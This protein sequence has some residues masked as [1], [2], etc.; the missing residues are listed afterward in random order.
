[1]AAR[2]GAAKAASC[3]KAHQ[4]RLVVVMVM[5]VAVFMRMVVLMGMLVAMFMGMFVRVGMAMGLTVMRVLMR[6]LMG[7]LVRVFMILEELLI[8]ACLLGAAA[9]TFTHIG[10]LDA[11]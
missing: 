1:M 10:L 2:Q 3:A 5:M 6:V 8:L 4:R 9:T 7:M 11:V